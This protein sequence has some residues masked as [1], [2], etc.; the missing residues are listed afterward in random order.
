MCAGLE[1][2]D[3]HRVVLAADILGWSIGKNV[4]DVLRWAR[5]KGFKVWSKELK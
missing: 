1:T 4:K 5:G 3:R 2:D